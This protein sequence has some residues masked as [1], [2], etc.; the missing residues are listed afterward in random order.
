M[1]LENFKF[2]LKEKKDDI[3]SNNNVWLYTRVSSKDQEMNKSLENQ[4]ES[5]YKY[6]KEHGYFITNTFGG[7]YE[8]ASGD[9]TRKEFAKLIQAVREAKDRPKAILIY[10][11]S[12]FSRTGGNGIALANELVEEL[13][14]NLI[15]VS[16]GKNTLTEDGKLEIFQGLIKANQE[17]LDRLKVTIPGMKSLLKSGNWLGNVPMGYDMFGPRVK[18]RRFYNEK[19]EIKINETGEKLR[20]AWKWK[21]QGEKDFEIIRKLAAMGVVTSKQRLSDIWRNPFYCGISVNKMLDEPVQGNWE[22]MI[23]EEDFW[24]VQEILK[25]NNFGFKQ[26]KAN[27]ARPLNAFIC[28]AKC[29]GRM[30]GYEVK[31]KKVHYYKCQFCKDATI[32]ADTTIRAKGEGANALFLILLKDY[33][34]PEAGKELYKAQLK[35]TY[36][37]LNWEKLQE[38]NQLQKELEKC[39]N[40]LKKI[41]RKY[42][43]DE[44]EKELYE[45]VKGEIEDKISKIMKNLQNV[46]QKISNLEDYID[47]SLKILSNV[48]KYWAKND[49]KTKK[50]IQETIFPDGISLDIKKRVYLTKKVNKLFEVTHAVSTDK[51]GEIKNGIKNFLMPSSQVAGTGFE[52]VTFG[53]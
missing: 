31:K 42:A 9:F 24:E 45:E 2:L 48:Y 26:D 49:L 33:Q 15:E 10:T 3:K 8:S 16:T 37:T 12:R 14:V 50:K 19:Q 1:A 30:T 18:Q 53:L 5:G 38:G 52:P 46:T 29:G 51:L 32:N 40:D 23:S 43:L 21:L 36:E 28:C 25:G 27:P 39:K 17:N 20:Q 35:L 6:A 41:K 34:L 47:K 22:K 11:M 13:G 4:K 7:T 44:I